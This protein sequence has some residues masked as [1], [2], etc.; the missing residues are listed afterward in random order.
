METGL[1]WEIDRSYV[2][3]LESQNWC[4]L[5]PDRF[6]QVTVFHRGLSNDSRWKDSIPSSGDSSYMH[7]GIVTGQRVKS[8]VVSERAFPSFF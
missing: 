3:V 1:K 7:D 6:S 5:S 2:S 4:K 8:I